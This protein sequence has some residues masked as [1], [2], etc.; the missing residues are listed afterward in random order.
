MKEKIFKI[1][2]VLFILLIPS[3]VVGPK[4]EVNVKGEIGGYVEYFEM[5]KS[6]KSVQKFLLQWYNS[7]SISCMSRME[8]EI[9]DS[10]N[11]ITSVWSGGKEMLPGVSRH[12]DAYW[13]PQKEGNYSVNIVIHH[14]QDIIES[15]PINFSVESVP[16]AEKILIIEA[17]NLP[18]KKIE[19][20]IKSNRD[21][22]NV[23]IIPSD[24]PPGWLFNGENIENVKGGEEIIKVLDYEPSVWSEERLNIQAFSFDGKYSSEKIDFFLKEEKY[25]WDKYSYGIFFI[26]LILL[27][28]SLTANLYLFLKKTITH[29]YRKL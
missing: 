16:T 6:V 1:I 19:V 20:K 28:L 2:I 18:E 7:E 8:F 5:E 4:I 10:E 21:L 22:K 14:C 11:Y 15:D 29:K 17:K 25:F 27:I 26:T 9:Y 3:L 13:L 24:Y 23:I 12:F